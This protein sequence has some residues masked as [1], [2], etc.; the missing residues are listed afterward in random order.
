MRASLNITSST[1]TCDPLSLPGLPWPVEVHAHPRARHL[2]LRLDEARGVLRLTVPHRTGRRAALDWAR[3]QSQWVAAQLASIEPGEPLDPGATIPFDGAELRLE[4]R[5][6][7]PRSPQLRDCAAG[8]AILSCAT[9]SCGGP[10]DRFADRI[11]AWL[12]AEARRR[13]SAETLRMAQAGGLADGPVGVGDA[14]TRWGS[15]SAS[16]AIR[17]NWRLLLAPPHVRAY[18]VAHEVAHR[19]HLDHKAGF[20]ALQAELYDGDVREARL[21]LRR[22]G[23]RLKRV[24]RG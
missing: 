4:W 14:S 18:V 9:L 13:L 22:I 17:Y 24:G 21:A 20:H 1:A 16:G 19:V 7:A 5:A 3:G 8:C 23:P 11:R 12:R 6:D 10:R 15:C 2:R